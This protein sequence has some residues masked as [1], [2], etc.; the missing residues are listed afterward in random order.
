MLP[1]TELF[2]SKRFAFLKIFLL[3][4]LSNDS[5]LTTEDIESLISN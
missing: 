2:K 3:E 5:D 4:L 1:K